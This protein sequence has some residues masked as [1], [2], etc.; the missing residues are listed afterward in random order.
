MSEP[1]L[2]QTNVR[3][4]NEK[5][6]NATD[7]KLH[8][9]LE[10]LH[11]RS[12][13]R[14]LLSVSVEDKSGGRKMILTQQSNINQGLDINRGVELKSETGQMM[15][16]GGKILNNPGSQNYKQSIANM[17][18]KRLGG[19]INLGPKV[20]VSQNSMVNSLA[21]AFRAT[22]S[23]KMSMLN[24]TAAGRGKSSTPGIS[25]KEVV[26]TEEET[27]Q[28]EKISYV[29]PNKIIVDLDTQQNVIVDMVDPN[30]YE[31]KRLSQQNLHD[32]KTEM[33]PKSLQQVSDQSNLQEFVNSST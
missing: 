30:F 24:S 17:T 27:Q 23:R 33:S 31:R 6:M 16:N 19:L 26:V 4:L 9:L 5:P 28:T 14:A 3:K 25:Q 1:Q 15:K 12:D 13:L 22:I 20:R 8:N 11:P 10:K 29:G 7:I 2:A 32:S 18:Q 21:E